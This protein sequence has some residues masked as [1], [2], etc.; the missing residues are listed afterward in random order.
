MTVPNSLFSN[1][2]ITICSKFGTGGFGVGVDVG[3]GVGVSVAV[4]GMGVRVCV[5]DGKGVGVSVGI[6][7]NGIQPA[8]KTNT[9]MKGPERFMGISVIYASFH[10]L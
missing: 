2:M 9:S 3:E 10:V 6:T 7:E 5:A 4:G 1:M 8:S